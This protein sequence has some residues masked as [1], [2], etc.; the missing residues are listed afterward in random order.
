MKFNLQFHSVF[1]TLA[2]NGICIENWDEWEYEDLWKV[3]H[4]LHFERFLQLHAVFIFSL[5][6]VVEVKW[7]LYFSG[8]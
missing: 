8:L 1:Y 3:M 4:L 6:E 2:L 5:E 7:R